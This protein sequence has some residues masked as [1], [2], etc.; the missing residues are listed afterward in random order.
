[1]SILAAVLWP[2]RA[3]LWALGAMVKIRDSQD[4]FIADLQRA[5]RW[6]SRAA[7]AACAAAVVSA[8]VAV[9]EVMR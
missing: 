1:L 2:A 6:N 8:I 4:H 3:V 5:G 7:L 9:G